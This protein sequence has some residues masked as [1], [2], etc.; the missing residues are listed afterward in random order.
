ML[1][2]NCNTESP[3]KSLTSNNTS[4]Y[5][6]FLEGIEGDLVKNPL[7]NSGKKRAHADYVL[8]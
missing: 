1:S 6:N 4:N 7:S 2:T 5:V 8:E 3:S